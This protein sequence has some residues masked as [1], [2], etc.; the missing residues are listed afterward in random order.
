MADW[1]DIANTIINLKTMERVADVSRAQQQL[2]DYMYATESRRQADNVLLSELVDVVVKVRKFMQDARYFDALLSAGMGIRAFNS[3]Y[4][5]I[6]E[7]EAKLKASDIQVRLLETMRSSL[8]DGST[9][10]SLERSFSEYLKSFMESLSRI[11][12]QLKENNYELVWVDPDMDPYFSIGDQVV[13]IRDFGSGAL[14]D[15]E[16]TKDEVYEVMEVVPDP[17]NTT[18]LIRLVGNSGGAYS[19]EFGE[20]GGAKNFAFFKTRLPAMHKELVAWNLCDDMFSDQALLENLSSLRQPMLA[21]YSQSLQD[22]GISRIQIIS[23]ISE[24]KRTRRSVVAQ[25]SQAISKQDRILQKAKEK[26]ILRE[27]IAFAV[28]FLI[29]AIMIIVFVAIG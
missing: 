4:Q 19:F 23:A 24:F 29:V 1:L 10:Q 17:P 12:G 7:A 27:R 15:K 3:I 22:A 6:S 14:A 28:A 26:K 8:A 16:F 21:L 18:K 25:C 11:T 13:R 20:K 2:A 5:T 9:G